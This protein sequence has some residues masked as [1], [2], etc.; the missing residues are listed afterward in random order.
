MGQKHN[1]VDRHYFSWA[2]SLSPFKFFI[3]STNLTQCPWTSIHKMTGWQRGKQRYMWKRNGKRVQGLGHKINCLKRHREDLLSR[4]PRADYQVGQNTIITNPSSSTL[5]EQFPNTPP[6]HPGYSR[7]SE[8]SCIVCYPCDM[9]LWLANKPGWKKPY[10]Q[11]EYSLSVIY[12]SLRASSK[13]R[14]KVNTF[15]S[16]PTLHLT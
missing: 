8:E 5:S 12:T 4:A 10:C 13:C 1:R 7:A 9:W 2:K 11:R 14:I 16:S 6:A 15:V 3:I